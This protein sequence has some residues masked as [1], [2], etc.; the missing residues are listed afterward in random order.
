[1]P[2]TTTVTVTDGWAVFHNG[3]QHNGGTV[4]DVDAATAAH[5]TANGWA[6]VGPPPTKGRARSTPTA[7]S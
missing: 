6:T 1:M 3:Q 7:G 5:W 2:D 4:L